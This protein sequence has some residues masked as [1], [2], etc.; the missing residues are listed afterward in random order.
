M[1]DNNSEN[2]IKKQKYKNLIFKI[3]FADYFC[4]SIEK[5]HHKI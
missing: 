5:F 3:I 4:K 1:L 2:K